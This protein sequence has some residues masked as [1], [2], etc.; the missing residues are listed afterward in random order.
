M[1]RFEFE[2]PA[3]LAQLEQ[4][5][6]KAARRGLRDLALAAHGQWQDE[7]GR[8]LHT[9][10]AQY[11]AAVKHKKVDADTYEVFLHHPTE[12]TNWLVTAIEVGY[13]SFNIR[14]ALLRSP[15]AFSYSQY[16]KVKGPGA[17]KVGAPFVDVPFRTGPAKTQSK[18]S[19]FRRVHP[20]SSKSKWIHPGFRPDGEGGLDTPL[21]E[22]V[23][24]YIKEEAKNVF[25]P[26]LA[27]ISV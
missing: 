22:A 3:D 8:K 13:P 1:I 21:R 18:P 24:D 7:A 16:A 14:D 25:G 26:F 20:G 27:K 12:K 4:K 2:T 10:R 15:S 17:A 23:K 19:Y 11:Q 9:T 6:I 5:L